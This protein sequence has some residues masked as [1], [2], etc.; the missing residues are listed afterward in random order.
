MF[1]K[2]YKACAVHWELSPTCPCGKDLLGHQGSCKR[3]AQ[4]RSLGRN[5]LSSTTYS[6][7]GHTPMVRA[8][9]IRTNGRKP[10][11][12][13]Q[14]TCEAKQTFPS[15]YLH[16]YRKLANTRCHFNSNLKHLMPAPSPDCTKRVLFSPDNHCLVC[17]RTHCEVQTVIETT[18]FPKH[19]SLV[20]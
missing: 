13:N 20:N 16:C 19:R 17:I 3:W 1:L 9:C 15:R 4:V 11:H 14:L 6:S 10:M 2:S 12:T 5:R 18:Q 8:Q 7:T